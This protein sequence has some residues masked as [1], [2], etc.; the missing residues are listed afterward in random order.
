MFTERQRILVTGASSGIGRAIALE[1]LRQ[2]ATVLACG[3]NLRRLDEARSQ[4][5]C[6]ERWINVPRD[7]LEDMEDL[8]LWIRGLCQQYG[9]LWGLAHAAGEG[10]MDSLRTYELSMARRHFDLAF[11]ASVL[12]AQGFCD[13]R[14]SCKGGALLFLTSVSAV[15]PEKG[16]LIYGAA[17]AALAAAAKAIS[18]EVAPRGVRVHCLAP[19][20][21]D[22]PLEEAAEAFMGS[23]YREEQL[24]GY[25]LGFGQAE[26]V[27]HMATFLL[28]EK[29]RWITGQNYIMAG[30]RY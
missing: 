19:G 23:S 30:G 17:K 10:I 7:L 18:Q 22:T 8:P 25:P 15:H 27:A 5:C 12:L 1:C 6:P 13:R 11:H 20:I 2:G 14:N 4:A 28:S 26:D 3:R 29:A 24:R 9:P 16:H 21:V